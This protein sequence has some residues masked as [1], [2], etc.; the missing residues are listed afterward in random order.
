MISEMHHQILENANR[1]LSRRF[2]KLRKAH[3]SRDAHTIKRA[4]MEYYQSLQHLY[5]AVQDAVADGSHSSPVGGE[6]TPQ[7]KPSDS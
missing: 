6:E 5:A 1:E 7:Q 3:A 4:E 2:A